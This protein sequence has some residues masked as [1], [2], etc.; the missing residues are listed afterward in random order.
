MEKMQNFVIFL[1]VLTGSATAH[2]FLN[3]LAPAGLWGTP[4]RTSLIIRNIRRGITAGT[5]FQGLGILEV[6]L[7]FRAVVRKNSIQAVVD[8]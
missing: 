2:T 6:P 4:G 1:F 5:I 3:R 7:G 8:A